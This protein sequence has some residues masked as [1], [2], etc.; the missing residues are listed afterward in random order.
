MAD[1][2]YAGFRAGV[3]ITDTR[4]TVPSGGSNE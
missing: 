4:K 3:A 2:F 1:D